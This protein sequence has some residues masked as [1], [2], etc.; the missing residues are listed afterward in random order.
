MRN[1]FYAIRIQK[2]S[3]PP[4]LA[5][6]NASAPNLF[7]FHEDAVKE[8][9]EV[10]KCEPCCRKCTPQKCDIVKVH[11]RWSDKSKTYNTPGDMFR[12]KE[13]LKRKSNG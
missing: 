3:F 9:E 12:S 5:R 8:L 10:R 6:H 2:G 7:W 13:E 11:V 1:Y 4:F